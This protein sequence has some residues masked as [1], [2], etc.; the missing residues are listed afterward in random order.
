MRWKISFQTENPLFFNH[1]FKLSIYFILLITIA[2][3][4]IFTDWIDPNQMFMTFI[5]IYIGIQLFY[6]LT[7]ICLFDHETLF[8]RRIIRAEIHQH[9]INLYDANENNDAIDHIEQRIQT[10]KEALHAVKDGYYIYLDH[11][12]NNRHFVLVAKGIQFRKKYYLYRL[13]QIPEK[14]SDLFFESED[15]KFDE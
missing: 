5:V 3:L 14:M 15:T 8:M 2:I 10:L 12:F 7:I 9:L 4:K 6:R 1:L 13:V 11:Q